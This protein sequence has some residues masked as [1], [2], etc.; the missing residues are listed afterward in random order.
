MKIYTHILI[1][2]YTSCSFLFL[3]FYHSIVRELV[4]RDKTI[5]NDEDEESHTAL[6]HAALN[7]NN[8]VVAALIKAGADIEA[9]WVVTCG[10]VYHSHIRGS[11]LFGRS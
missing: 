6:H 3:S 10:I 5:L 9:R 11:P 7:G 8:K 2:T 1:F 4:R